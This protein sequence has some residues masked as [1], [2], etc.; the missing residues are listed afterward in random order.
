LN[1]YLWGYSG[2]T[3]DYADQMERY[4]KD[5]TVTGVSD[6][7]EFEIGATLLPVLEVTTYSRATTKSST[8]KILLLAGENIATVGAKGITFTGAGTVTFTMVHSVKSAGQTQVMYAQPITVTV[9]GAEEESSSVIVPDETSGEETTLPTEDT[10]GGEESTAVPE[11]KGC[12][13][14]MSV[15]TMALVCAV[16]GAVAVI[17]KKRDEEI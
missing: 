9:T 10:A 5:V 16:A 12:K 8:A 6:G 4:L 15:G 7:D 2:L 13:S 1:Q 11:T 3:G 14:M 17:A